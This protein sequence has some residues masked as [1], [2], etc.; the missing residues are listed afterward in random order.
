MSAQPHP[1]IVPIP[2]PLPGG[3]S[4][5]AYFIDAPRPTLID[6]GI[7]SSPTEAIAAALRAHGRRLEEVRLVVN[8]HGHWDH[9]G[10]DAVLRERG[11]EITIHRDDV[12][13]LR[14]RRRHASGYWGERVRLAGKPPEGATLI[15]EH[16][17]GELEPDRELA[18]GD[19]IDLGGDVRLVVVHTP[20]HSAGS[21]SFWWEREGVLLVGDAVQGAGTLG[22]R[23]P[24]YVDPDPYRASLTAM[25]ELGARALCGGHDFRWGREAAWVDDADAVDAALDESLRAEELLREG[26]ASSDGRAKLAAGLGWPAGA[27]PEPLGVTL[28]G[29][30]R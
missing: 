5:Y 24:F 2:C 8:T 21:A 14:S 20:G 26:A 13:L 15:F 9:L 4:V 25:R 28:A 30:R 22:S 23:C 27:V 12:P 6:A 3:G 17:A 16:I 29:Y 1:R 18:H 10:G 7:A 11:A 19:E